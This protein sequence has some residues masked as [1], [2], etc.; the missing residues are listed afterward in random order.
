MSLRQVRAAARRLPRR[1][2]RRLINDELSGF[3][4]DKDENIKYNHI[5]MN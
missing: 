1:N 3:C 5:I 2:D 4:V